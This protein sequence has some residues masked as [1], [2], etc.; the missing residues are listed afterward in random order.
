MPH[1]CPGHRLYCQG[2]LPPYRLHR[3]RTTGGSILDDLLDEDEIPS[4]VDAD[5]C[6]DRWDD[7]ARRSSRQARAAFERL[8]ANAPARAAFTGVLQAERDRLDK[9]AEVIALRDDVDIAFCEQPLE[10]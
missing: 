1:R 7:R 8:L 5:H 6:D 2:C 10:V 4:L 9:A 3:L